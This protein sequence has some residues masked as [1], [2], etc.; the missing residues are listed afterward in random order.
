M[1]RRLRGYRYILAIAIIALMGALFINNHKA[2]ASEIVLPEEYY[3]VFNGMHRKDGSEL[4]LKKVNTILQVTSG[5]WESG[6][7]EVEWISSEPRV[8]DLKMLMMGLI[9]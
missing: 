3:F 6:D 5:T 9:L 2:V 4:E 8:V 7:T 1:N